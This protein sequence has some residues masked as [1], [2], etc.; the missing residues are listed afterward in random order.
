[1]EHAGLFRSERTLVLHG[2]F[3][4]MIEWLK[5]SSELPHLPAQIIRLGKPSTADRTN[6]AGNRPGLPSVNVAFL[7]G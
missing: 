2:Q 6:Q 5:P 1:M 7:L 4:Q 3:A